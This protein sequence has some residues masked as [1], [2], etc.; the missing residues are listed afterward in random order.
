MMQKGCDSLGVEFPIVGPGGSVQLEVVVHNGELHL[1]LGRPDEPGVAELLAAITKLA[2]YTN[3][4]GSSELERR[5]ASL[6][7][8][9]AAIALWLAAQVSA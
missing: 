6:E 7:V 9:D 3:A 2:D 1:V 4:I 8:A 5:A